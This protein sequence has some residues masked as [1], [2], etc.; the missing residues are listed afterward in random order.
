MVD[1]GRDKPGWFVCGQGVALPTTPCFTG[2]APTGCGEAVCV[3]EVRF[4]IV[5]QPPPLEQARS[6]IGGLDLVLDDMRQRRLHDFTRLIHFL[7]GP[8]SE[9]RPEAV[10]PPH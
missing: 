7:G 5:H 1:R 6:G 8:I 9:R 10:R 3:V 4:P 2:S